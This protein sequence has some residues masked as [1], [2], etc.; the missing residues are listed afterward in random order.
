MLHKLPFNTLR[1]DLLNEVSRRV[2]FT[3]PPPS[4]FGLDRDPQIFSESVQMWMRYC[5]FSPGS[6]IRKHQL[7]SPPPRGRAV[8]R[9]PWPRAVCRILTDTVCDLQRQAEQ[10][11]VM[12][13]PWAPGLRPTFRPAL[14]LSISYKHTHTHTPLRAKSQGIQSIWM[15]MRR[16]RCSVRQICSPVGVSPVKFSFHISYSYRNKVIY[17]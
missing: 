13:S 10:M 9:L 16:L 5:R 2:T 8:Y 6:R 17:K 15:K 7:C 4:T 1:S 11:L 14:S 3:F 12:R